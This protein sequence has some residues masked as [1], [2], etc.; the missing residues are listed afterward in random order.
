[1]KKILSNLIV[2]A[3]G[4]FILSSCERKFKNEEIEYTSNVKGFFKKVH[5]EESEYYKKTTSVYD[6][7]SIKS[8][9]EDWDGERSFLPSS[10]DHKLLKVKLYGSCTLSDLDLEIYELNLEL[11]DSKTGMI[12]KPLLSL[13]EGSTFQGLMSNYKDGYVVYDIPEETLLKDLY[14]GLNRE[15]KETNWT[16][17]NVS[18]M[19]SLDKIEYD[20]I[21]KT[22]DLS[23]TDVVK[24]ASYS[25]V[26]L[27]FK[28]I[29]LNCNDEH[30]LAYKKEHEYYALHNVVKLDL[31]IIL[32]K[33][34]DNEK[35][36]L[37]T[38]APYLLTEYKLIPDN[39]S[40]FPKLPDNIKRGETLSTSLYYVIDP[41]HNIVS[42]SNNDSYKTDIPKE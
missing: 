19:L 15:L 25:E 31:D 30:A 24:T 32:G 4:V 36:S 33:E 21:P 3:I 14:I 39:S 26:K 27:K 40:N 35:E 28:S 7:F 34:N 11:F 18:E 42:L 16:K 9:I 29:T 1:M 17:E 2:L 8:I 13:D 37:Y 41:G 12:Y 38:V 10:G 5:T 6:V 22:I 20:S 23:K